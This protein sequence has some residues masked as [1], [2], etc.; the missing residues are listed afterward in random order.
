MSS[1]ASVI[2]ALRVKSV[3]LKENAVDEN[4]DRLLQESIVPFKLK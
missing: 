1:A 2:G 3:P 4:N